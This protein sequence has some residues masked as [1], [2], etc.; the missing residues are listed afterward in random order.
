VEY[1]SLLGPASLSG[2]QS[3]SEVGHVRLGPH[4]LFDLVDPGVAT[5][6]TFV[7]ATGVD[8]VWREAASRYWLEP[9]TA[10]AVWAEDDPPRTIGIDDFEVADTHV[11]FTFRADDIVLVVESWV[12]ALHLYSRGVEGTYQIWYIESY[13]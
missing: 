4:L 10:I 1:A 5:L 11:L 2:S 12:V 3:G 8:R 6:L 9:A 13:Y 7:N